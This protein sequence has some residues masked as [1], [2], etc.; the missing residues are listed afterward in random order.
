MLALGI[1]PDTAPELLPAGIR[2]DGLS[3]L[4]GL[5]TRWLI[6]WQDHSDSHS[7]GNNHGAPTRIRSECSKSHSSTSITKSHGSR[8]RSHVQ[9]LGSH[10]RTCAP[11]AVIVRTR[12]KE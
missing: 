2:L 5:R 9:P 7:Q 6:D 8:K 3:L 10:A 4:F 12:R 1:D 11:L